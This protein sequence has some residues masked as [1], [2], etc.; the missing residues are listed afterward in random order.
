MSKNILRIKF[1][2]QVKRKLNNTLKHMQKSL[3]GSARGPRSDVDSEYYGNHGWMVDFEPDSVINMRLR[4]KKDVMSFA[5]NNEGNIYNN[6][7]NKVTQ[8]IVK[9]LMYYHFNSL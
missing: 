3:L 1:D 2:D 7:I 6:L 4:K 8:S 5:L 9:Y